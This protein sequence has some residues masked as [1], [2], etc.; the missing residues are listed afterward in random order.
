MT[1][2]AQ[3]GRLRATL[4]ATR[5]SPFGDLDGDGDIDA[6]V[7]ARRAASCAAGATTAAAATL[8]ARASARPRQQPQRRRRRRSSCARAACGSGI[9][10]SAA[11]PAVAP[12]DIVFGLGPRAAADVVRVLWPSGTCR[13]RPAATPARRRAA[14]AIVTELD[15]K[16]SSCPFLFTWNGTRFEFVTDFMGGGEMGYWEAPGAWNTPD[17]DEYVRISRRSAA[18]AK[19]GRYELRVTNE[20]E[21]ALFVDRLQLVA[22]DHPRDVDVLSERRARAPAGAPFAS[23]AV[24]E[25]R[26]RRAARDD[27]GHD[28]L[29]RVD[30]DRS[31]VP[32]RLHA[33]GDPRLRRA[34][35]ADAR[36]RSRRRPT[37]CCC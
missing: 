13:P 25:P 28:V 22:V 37:P 29:D 10:T 20:L 19:D 36:S 1:A 2:G 21:E 14:V 8:A 5:R 15:R 3:L 9:E 27:H 4:D 6:I 11:T 32:R 17:P 12:A 26:A 30:A 16:P 34:A 18:P 23:T 7:A 35:R 33:D 24:R 31:R